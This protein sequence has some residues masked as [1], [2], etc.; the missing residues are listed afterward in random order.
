MPFPIVLDVELSAVKELGIRDNLS[1]PATFILDK[2]GQVRFAYVGTGI[3]DRPSVKAILN[4]LDAL[5]QD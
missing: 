1:K 2:Y 5:N 3:A 4:Q